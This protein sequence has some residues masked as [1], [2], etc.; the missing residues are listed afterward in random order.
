MALAKDAAHSQQL[1]LIY[2]FYRLTLRSDCGY[3]GFWTRG[4]AG[5]LVQP[6]HSLC[7]VSGYE[8]RLQ[9]TDQQLS[10]KH[11]VADRAGVCGRAGS[12][13]LGCVWLSQ[14]RTMLLYWWLGPSPRGG[15]FP[16]RWWRGGADWM[17][18]GSGTARR[19]HGLL[20]SAE[21]LQP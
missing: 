12:S 1:T 15:H 21:G 16:R 3:G 5:E 10:T 4:R 14:L 8:Q 18:P 17:L 9:K 13:R 11:G 7:T 20:S 6:Q 2:C 19:D